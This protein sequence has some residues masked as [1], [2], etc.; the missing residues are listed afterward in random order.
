[1]EIDAAFKFNDEIAVRRFSSFA[2][3][4]VAGVGGNVEAGLNVTGNIQPG[5]DSTTIGPTV[6]WKVC[7]NK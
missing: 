3:R 5:A 6:K 1:M 4:V 7:E 2:P